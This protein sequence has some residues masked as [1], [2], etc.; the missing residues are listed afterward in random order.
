M[1]S[2]RCYVQSVVLPATS[3]QW[4]CYVQ[5]VVLPTISV[6]WDLSCALLH[7]VCCAAYLQNGSNNGFAVM[8]LLHS[9]CYIAHP[10][11]TLTPSYSYMQFVVL[12]TLGSE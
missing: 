3:V 7:A 8:G 9:V 10:Q 1:Y 12:L 5:S 6:Q 2:G 11:S 4:P